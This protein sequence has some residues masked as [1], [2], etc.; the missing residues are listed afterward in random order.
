MR[1]DYAMSRPS[2]RS[3]T[4]LMTAIILLFSMGTAFAKSPAPI[5]SPQPKWPPV[6]F[7]SVDGVFA[8]IP[9][10]SELV[11]LLSAK[12]TLQA[13]VKQCQKFSCGAV[14]VAAT[15]GCLWWEVNSSLFRYD[16]SN[17]KVKI[18]SLT[19]FDSGSGPK[20]QKTIFLIS[21]AAYDDFVSVGSIKVLCHRNTVNQQNPGNNYLPI[22]SPNP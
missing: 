2:R 3:F 4:T 1:E 10:Q 15:N 12:T 13:T 14:I 8:K 18:G 9:T 20:A 17:N 19:T 21:G 6:G 16:S 5:P 22:E 11:G 7:K